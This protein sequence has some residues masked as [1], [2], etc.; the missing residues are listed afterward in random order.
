MSSSC[1]ST[2]NETGIC[3]HHIDLPAALF[4]STDLR[5]SA[6]AVHAGCSEL[7]GQPPFERPA[8]RKRPRSAE[9]FDELRARGARRLAEAGKPS[10]RF[11]GLGEMNAEQ[12][13]ETTMD[14]QSR[15]AAQVDVEDAVA[16]RPDLLD[17]D[18]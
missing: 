2:E 17:A 8:R 14:P 9:T 15:T 4:E 1:A 10:S 12:L 11:K 7:A 3:A 13:W 5:A 6:H 18:G 16:G